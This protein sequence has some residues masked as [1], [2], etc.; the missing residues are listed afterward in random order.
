[1]RPGVEQLP[2]FIGHSQEIRRVAKSPASSF[3]SLAFLWVHS[4]ASVSY[5]P[6]L[7]GFVGGLLTNRVAILP[8]PIKRFR[9]RFTTSSG[10]FRVFL[11]YTS[12]ITT[13]ST[14]VRYMIRQ[15]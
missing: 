15:L 11:S 5:L 2:L 8:Y 1:M 4:R 10:I 14:S 13:A 3:Q 9:Q 7:G 6:F 12:K